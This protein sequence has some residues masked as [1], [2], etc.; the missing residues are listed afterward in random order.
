MFEKYY[1]ILGLEN[2]ATK[3]DI[4]SA[5]R[6]L[7]KKFHPDVS[8]EPDAGKRFIEISEA[9]EFLMNRN[10]IDDMDASFMDAT[11]RRFTYEYFAQRARE[12]AKRAA[13]M[14]Y[15]RLRNEHEA[16]QKSGMYDILLLLNYALHGFLVLLSV[17]IMV[18]PV[19]IAIKELFFGLFFFYIPGIFLIA[20]IYSERRRF[21]RLGTFYYNYQEIKNMIRE[22]SGSGSKPCAYAVERPAD[23]YPFKISLLTIHKISLKLTG[24]LWH[25]ASYQRSYEKL[26]IPRSK[27]S[28]R[29]HTSGSVFK[30]CSIL[31]IIGWSPLECFI[32]DLIL[33]MLIGGVL[34][35]LAGLIFRVR[36]KISYLLTINLIVKILAWLMMIIMFTDFSEFPRLQTHEYFLSGFVLMLLLQDLLVEP[37]TRLIFRKGRHI[38]PLIQQPVAMQ[39]LYRKGYQSYLEIPVW[40]T[41]FPMVKWIF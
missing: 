26:S 15:E 35:G 3:D 41:V 27:I 24:A 13:E 14:K 20:Y 19:Y 36:S 7:A 31:F 39:R 17:F 9:Y 18:F 5:Y 2:K 37:L 23:A 10:I 4:K 38:R 21:F 40:S 34:A 11:E 33:G 6:L 16:F 1:R 29:V 22:E 12:N 8:D 28:F 25:Q 30:V 32:W